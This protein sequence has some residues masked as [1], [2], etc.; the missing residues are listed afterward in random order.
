MHKGSSI[1]NILAVY[2]TSA[3]S[4]VHFDDLFDFIIIIIITIIII[5]CHYYCYYYQ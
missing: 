3:S 1:K 4:H 5:F 2:V